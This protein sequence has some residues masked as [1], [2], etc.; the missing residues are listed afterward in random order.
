ME[1]LIYP[2]HAVIFLFLFMLQGCGAVG[3]MVSYRF[4]GAEE[5]AL[6]CRPLGEGPFP[7]VVYSHALIVDLNGYQGAARRGYDLDGICQ[8]LA[9]DGFLA[10]APIRQSGPGN[11]PRHKEEASRAIDY[12]KTLP[13]VDA[14]RIALMGFS[15]GG[16]LTLMVGLER[17]DLKALLILA[18]APGEG[19]FAEAVK[20]ISSLR[21]PVLLLVEASDD[22][23]ILENSSALERALLGPGGEVRSIRYNRGG[24]HRLF[25]DA[26]YYWNDVSAFLREKLGEIPLP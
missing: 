8:A 21:A 2:V 23:R 11:I 13:D 12:V 18:P 5:K 20:R 14:S 24:G 10:F 9:A 1:T 7:T 16:L 19:H 15:R 4:G 6:L 22:P 26:G 17:K 25:Y 3:S